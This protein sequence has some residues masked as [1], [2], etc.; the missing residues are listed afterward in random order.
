MK[1]VGFLG[2]G[3]MAEALARG[4]LSNGIVA[5][6]A[7]LQAYDI[8]PARRQVFKE[9]L[10]ASVHDSNDGVVAASDVV[11]LAVKPQYAKATLESVAAKT[12]DAPGKVLV[13]IAAG[14]SLATL[15]SYVP[16]GTSVVRVMPNTPCMVGESASALSL[17]THTTKEQGETVLSLMSAVG[18]AFAV[19]EP[20][21]D[22][23]TG[24]SG[25]GPAYVF[26]MIEALSD[27]GVRSGLTRNVATTLA[28]QTVMGAAK[29]VRT[30]S[31]TP[32]RLTDLSPNRV[33][34]A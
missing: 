4:F 3:M 16:S 21:L 25:S 27:G 28:A 13:S 5:S 33:R 2:A 12:W 19:D 18:K 26:M 10:G 14:V 8:A 23:V 7:G 17:G 11:F 20:Y 30:P 9:S 1:S 31:N 15:E 6:G 34:V 32:T 24:L 29:M 22:A